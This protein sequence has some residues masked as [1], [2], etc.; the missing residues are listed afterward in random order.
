M[1]KR[2]TVTTDGQ[3]GTTP[4]TR[5]STFTGKGAKANAEHYARLVEARGDRN[6]RVDHETKGAPGVRRPRRARTPGGGQ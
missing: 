6:V 1:G 2:S 4:G 3:Q 5:V